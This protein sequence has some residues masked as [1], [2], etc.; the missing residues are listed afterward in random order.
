MQIDEIDNTLLLLLAK[1]GRAPVATL[2][3]KMNLA[4]TTVQARL[5]RLEV[6]G[7]IAGYT[8]RLGAELRPMIRATTLVSIEP[9]AAPAVLARLKSLPQV[10]KV[11]TTSGRFDLMIE[12]AAKTPQELDETIDYIGMTKGVIGSESLVH[13]TTKIDRAI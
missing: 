9:R 8:V 3:R 12:I 11:H 10:E 1:D 5:D 7:V 2:A 13:L 6:S 4:R